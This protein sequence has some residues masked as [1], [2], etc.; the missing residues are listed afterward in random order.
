MKVR[1]ITTTSRPR[2]VA[3]QIAEQIL[4]GRLSPLAQLPPER[5]LATQF[6][7]SR[8]AVREAVKILQTRGLVE[9]KQGCG[10][11]VTGDP[12]MP[13]QQAYLDILKGEKDVEYK[14]LEM[15][16]GLETYVAAIA[17]QRATTRDLKKINQNLDEFRRHV[18]DLDLCAE[19]D[20][21]FHRLIVDS[22]QNKLFNLILAP[23]AV[24]LLEY[25]RRSLK[26]AD[27]LTVLEHHK[28]V[29]EAIEAKDPSLASTLMRK[30][31]ETAYTEMLDNKA[32]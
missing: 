11:I 25:R 32:E 7:V 21:E 9:I 15:R 22:S 30:H 6:G 19:L 28:A 5:N 27:R 24:M 31:L 16:I 2:L 10:T 26:G 3:E 17:A 1:K 13:V 4:S 8:N 29:V 20:I 14:L 18:E 23:M 12:T